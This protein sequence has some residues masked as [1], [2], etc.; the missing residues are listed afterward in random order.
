[1]T[2]RVMSAGQGFKYLLKSV[3]SGDADRDLGTPLT[4]YYSADGVPPGSWLGSGLD[5]IGGEDAGRLRSGDPVT[6]EQLARL[7]GAGVDP[8][9]GG[10]LGAGYLRLEPPSQRIAARVARLDAA[11]DETHR[12]QQVQQIRDEEHART[13]RTAVAGFDLTFSPPKSLSVLWGVTDA[14]TQ[15]LFA[16]AHHAALRDTLDLLEHEVAATRVG[17]GGIAA[18]PVR[19]VIA[20]AFDH[21]D[22]RAGDP[23]L[24]THVVVSNKVQGTDGKWRTLDSRTLHKATVALSASYNAF[25]TDHTARLLDVTWAFVDRGRDRNTGW[26]ISGVPPELLA[27]FSRRTHGIP[28]GAEGID[29]AKDR[30]IAEYTA[31]HGRPPSARTVAK[32]RQ[33]ATLETRPAKE[34][35]SLAELTA[36]WRQRATTV[37]GQ[38]ATTW[39]RTLL[40]SLPSEP[41]L[42]S[43]DLQFDQVHDFAAVVLLEVGNRRATWG[44]WNL[45]AEAARQTMGLRFDTTEDRETVIARIVDRAEAESV[46]VAPEYDR[47][48]PEKFM[49]PDGSH[50]FRRADAVAYTSQNVLDAETRLLAHAA[51]TTGTHLPQL[52]AHRHISRRIRGVK[53]TD[54]QA[55]AILQ[56][57]I[58]GRVL[59]VLVGPAGAGKTTALRALHRAWASAHGR[60]SVIGLAPSAAAAEVL[61]QELGIR[62]ENTAKF[63]HEFEHDRWN[64]RPG[65]LVLVDEASLAGT[66]TLDRIT[67]H[68][69]TVGAKVVLVGDH[70]QLS[71]VETG[72]A[73]GMLARARQDTAELTDVRRFRGEWEKTASLALRRGD[74]AVL[75]TYEQ[76]GRIHDGDQD[77]MLDAAYAAWRSDREAGCRSVMIAATAQTVAALNQRARADLVATGRVEDSGVALH[78]GTTAGVGDLIVTRLNERRLTTGGAAWVKNGDR[79]LVSDRFQDG[80]LAIRRLGKNGAP[81]GAAVTLPAAY[82]AASV[83]LGYATTVHRVQ[84]STVDT[85]HAVIDPQSANRELLYVALTRGA[86]ANHAYVINEPDE[87]IERHHDLTTPTSGTELLAAVLAR[88]GADQSATETMRLAINEHAALT[89][90][91]AEYETIAEHAQSERWAAAIQTAPLDEPALDDVL[92]SPYYARLEQALRRSE[93]N[94]HEPERVLAA[95]A[96][97]FAASPARAGE[98]PADPAVI[99]ARWIDRAAANPRQ[100]PSRHAP[101]RVAGLLP[102]AVGAM[103]DDMRA[104]LSQRQRLIEARARQLTLADLKDGAAWIRKLGA[105]GRDPNQ[106]ATWLRLATTIRLYRERH[107]VT[108]PAP[109]GSPEQVRGTEQAYEYRAAYAAYA[110]ARYITEQQESRPRVLTGPSIKRGLTL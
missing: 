2:I 90:L 71:A 89:T 105:P 9:T 57:A 103:G 29:A 94:G 68:A 8:V 88:P 104:A 59:D 18:M 10:K 60:D 16:Q 24:H 35:H 99:L 85:A 46:R 69:A 47:L 50:W 80:S 44:R 74:P 55:A 81:H 73:F 51:D 6:E 52:L 82:V 49:N 65:Q 15:T 61:G 37:L 62:T 78:D 98:E 43:D 21:H 102:S 3:A 67:D 109:L 11:L 58:S 14:R 26:E 95:A 92:T 33:R 17:H 91:L 100:G 48:V 19:G 13:S 4:R 87:T 23:Q 66:L 56:L 106:Q 39:A 108:G 72:G 110:Q 64:L 5:A 22:T 107:N 25:L 7:L 40:T 54:D 41:L 42:G 53:L 1:M 20:A 97:A 79:W 28:G 86:D 45:H 101:R 63:L 70:A 76:H 93:S 31:A 34:L 38:D 77:T 30:L 36:D 84:G 96:R 27:E 32:L 83:E 75:T 12:A